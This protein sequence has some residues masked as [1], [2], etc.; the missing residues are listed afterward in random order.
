MS[1]N[2]TVSNNAV[3]TVC[4]VSAHLCFVF[5]CVAVVV[6]NAT[7]VTWLLMHRLELGLLVKHLN[8]A[9]R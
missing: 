6:V 4:V 8:V 2:T 9:T 5:R 3:T 1:E 7:E